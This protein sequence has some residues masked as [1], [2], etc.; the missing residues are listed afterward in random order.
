[1]TQETPFYPL[2]GGLD[3]ITPAIVMKPGKVIAGRNYEPLSNG[4]SRMM[5]YERYDGRTAPSAATY[6]FVNFDAGAS[7]FVVGETITGFTSGATGRV[8]ELATVVSG[9]YGASN[10]VGYVVLGRVS[11]A[12]I[13]NELLKNGGTTRATVNGVPTIN[14]APDDAT[15]MR[16]SALAI[17]D[18]RTLIA[19]VPG[20]GPVRGVWRL[21]GVTYAFRDNAG[22]TAGV[23]FKAASTGWQ[24]I[25]FDRMINFTS[26]GTY[27]IAEGD[28]ITGATSGA[29]AVVRRVVFK[30]GGWGAGT[31]EGYLVISGQTGNFAAENLNVGA[32]LNVATAPANSSAITLPPGGRYEFIN[33]N[34]YAS[35]GTLRTY[36]ANGVGF[37]FEFDGTYFVPIITGMPVDT[38][39]YVG[40]HKN[41]L[42]LAFPGGSLQNS[43]LGEPLV[44][45]AITGAAE[46][47][48]GDEITGMIEDNANLL[49]VLSAKSV[50]NLYG[51]DSADFQ[52]EILSSEAG[53]L[54]RT[55]QKLGAGIYMDNVGVRSISATQN[56][57]NLSIGTY[58]EIIQPLLNS[59]IKA[60][61]Q[62]VASCV[63]R[64]KTQYRI[65]FSNGDGLVIYLGKK[66]PEILP[67]DLGGKVPSSICSVEDSDRLERVFV[68][69][70]DGFVYQLESGTSFDG[71]N[72][73]YF[74]RLPFNHFGSPQMRKRW[75]K[76]IVECDAS[77]R[78]SVSV[79][80]D[81]D[82]GD[83]FEAGLDVIDFVVNG[84]GGSWDISNWDEFYWSS[85]AQGF[86]EAPLDGVSKN[87]SLLMAGSTADEP[88][89]LLHGVS[90]FYTKRG[91][92]R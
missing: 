70:D 17:A 59:Y 53:A 55:A 37:G 16:W 48:L 21:K 85:T 91:L 6:L 7:A 80:A 28:T 89:H 31:A 25:T 51:N 57:G 68:G 67:F 19:A 79:S 86:M 40:A 9:S 56:Y 15:D 8:L 39:A 73:D 11:G 26:G 4:Y 52:L 14:A 50:A 1:M 10:A 49:T 62:P 45:N 60:G 2:G 78:A 24:A 5:G 82:Y 69:C 38:P 76:A 30:T 44:F 75:H 88:P 43:S 92:A 41:H 81:L 13:D 90:I 18:Q 46:I 87:I 23:M 22:A 84:G 58:T 77:P 83:P 65:F 63:V 35:S 72:I 61:I 27:V 3:L 33:H 64:T 71:A 32:N 20:S 34:F 29:T 74:L 36:G 12:F 47:G 42:F 54:P 66:Q